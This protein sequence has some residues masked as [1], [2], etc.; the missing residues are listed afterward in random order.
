VDENVSVLCDASSGDVF[1]L[2]VTTVHCVATDDHS[3]TASGSFTVTV[4][5]TTA[6]DLTLPSNI[7]VEATGPSGAAVSFSTSATDLV[8]GS[9]AVN[10][11][12]D[13]GDTFPLGTTTVSRTATRRTGASR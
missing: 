7:T 4:Q 8:D 6:P 12:A 13:S 9:V 3:N 1:P 11:D 2:G 10:C 5:D